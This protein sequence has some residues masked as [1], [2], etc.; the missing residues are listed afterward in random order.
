MIIANSLGKLGKVMHA[1]R[2]LSFPCRSTARRRRREVKKDFT[3][4]SLLQ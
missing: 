4:P 3:Q 1:E 2:T